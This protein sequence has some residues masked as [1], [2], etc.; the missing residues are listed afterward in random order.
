MR[1][2]VFQQQS[3]AIHCE[4]QP[5][6]LSEVCATGCPLLEPDLQPGTPALSAEGPRDGREIMGVNDSGCG[7]WDGFVD[8]NTG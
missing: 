2:L 6:R 1:L 5:R 7:V 4:K 8:F 3:L